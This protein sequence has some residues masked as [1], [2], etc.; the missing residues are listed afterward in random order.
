MQLVEY[1]VSIYGVSNYLSGRSVSLAVQCLL[2]PD[3]VSLATST[4]TGE[5]FK[6]LIVN[7]EIKFQLSHYPIVLWPLSYPTIP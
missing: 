6:P 3:K 5:L 7:K 2:L 4:F 1:K